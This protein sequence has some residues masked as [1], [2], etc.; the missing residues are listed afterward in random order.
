MGGINASRASSSSVW[1]TGGDTLSITARV[2]P[3][4]GTMGRKT[5]FCGTCP[6]LRTA[7]T[8]APLPAAGTPSAAN[9][10]STAAKAPNTAISAGGSP[11]I[12]D[13]VCLC[14]MCVNYGNY[15]INQNFDYTPKNSL[16]TS[17]LIDIHHQ[18]FI[19]WLRLI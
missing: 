3:E 10:G 7:V 14:F 17:L 13:L 4:M 15:K 2:R 1:F 8:W 18:C 5:R 12:L 6:W 19:N 9:A 11:I 16:K